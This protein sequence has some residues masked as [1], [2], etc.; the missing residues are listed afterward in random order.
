ML[1]PAPVFW[2]L[3]PK[4]L[5]KVLFA[6]VLCAL[7]WCTVVGGDTGGG[8]VCRNEVVEVDYSANRTIYNDVKTTH[9]H[10]FFRAIKRG[11]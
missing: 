11:Q 5:N 6:L 4:Q 10:G 7:R 2:T 3:L 1:Y 9:R 8:L